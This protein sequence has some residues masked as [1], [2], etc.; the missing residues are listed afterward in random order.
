MSVGTII[1]PSSGVSRSN[2]NT[3]S[4]GANGSDNYP[5]GLESVGAENTPSSG[6][7]RSNE[8]A[9]SIGVSGSNYYPQHWCQWER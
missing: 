3:L 2:E 6:V 7:S 4:I 1:T 9:P 8:N 5:P